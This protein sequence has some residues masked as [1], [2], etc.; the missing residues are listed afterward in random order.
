MAF[1]AV[2]H[3]PYGNLQTLPVPTHKW[4]DLSID[5]VTGLPILTD[6]K[7]ESY[8]SILVIID[9]LTKMVHY[10]PMKITIDVPDLTKV[11]IDIVVW[12]HGLPNSIITDQGFLFMSK[13]WFLLCYF[14]GIKRRLSM[15][16]HPQI[17][18]QTKRQNSIMKAYFKAFVN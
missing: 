1:K 13:F 11:I 17:D 14:L 16:F 15:A 7:G 10:E 8:D 18:G 2:W 9:R 5:F 4:K 6:W 3:K 12:H